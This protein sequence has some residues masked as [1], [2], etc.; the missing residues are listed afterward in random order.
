MPIMAKKNKN[1][2]SFFGGED[3]FVVLLPQFKDIFL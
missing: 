3:F 2:H 1:I